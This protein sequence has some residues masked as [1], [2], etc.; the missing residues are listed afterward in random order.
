LKTSTAVA[1]RIS[2]L[3]AQPREPVPRQEPC[4]EQAEQALLGAIIVNNQAFERV[5]DI[6]EPGHF[7]WPIHGEIFE[8]AAKL[9]QSGKLVTATTLAPFFEGAEPISDSLTVPKYL[10][11]LAANA[12]TIINAPDYARTIVDLADHR[13]MI[14]LG[15]DIVNAGYDVRADES[16]KKKL[17]EFQARADR[18]TQQG[19][20]ERETSTLADAMRETLQATADAYRR[21]GGIAGLSTG[22]AS[23]DRKT[24]GLNAGEVIIAAGRPGMGKTAL[25][26]EIAFRC[27]TAVVPVPVGFLSLEMSKEQLAY[28]IKALLSGVSAFNQMTGNVDERQFR[29]LEEAERDF[30]RA[31]LHVDDSSGLSIQQ[32]VSRARRMKRKHGIKLLI[33]DYL[34]LIHGS[35]YRGGNN[36]TAEV[37]EVSS[38]MKVLA[39]ELQIPLLVL[40]QL[41][42]QVEQRTPPRPQMGDLRESGAIES[43]ADQVWLLFREEYYLRQSEPDIGHED[44]AAWEAKL[45]AVAG[46]A[47]II[48]SKQRMG[49]GGETVHVA[50]LPEL[51]SFR[52]LSEVR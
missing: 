25:A 36:R 13:S 21:G 50:F 34:Q 35:L 46:R 5:S 26:T 47:E 29:K 45:E 37:G 1:A 8:T 2:P 51:T 12:T 44:R 11:T 22:I 3:I 9:I 43:D 20:H 15:E 48:L 41:N 6:I 38:A 24:G 16:A 18:I 30:E 14:I 31:P 28:R 4:N 17:E 52:D 39:K 40:S 23:L 10:G 19:V 33:I 49:A 32:V 7:R 27:A 42:R